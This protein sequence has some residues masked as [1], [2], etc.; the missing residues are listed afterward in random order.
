MGV[1]RGGEG[2]EGSIGSPAQLLV[3]K[4]LLSQ[5]AGGAGLQQGEFMTLCENLLSE[6]TMRP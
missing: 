5:E 2:R 6:L 4:R 3:Q 1:G